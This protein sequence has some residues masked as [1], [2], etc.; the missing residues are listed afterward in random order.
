[1]YRLTIE[2]S[3]SSAHQLRGYKGKCENLHGHNWKVV[4]TVQG[5]TLNNIGILV[6]F[7]D[8]KRM[9]RD[10]LDE[11]DHI[12]MNEHEAFITQNP[13]SE[14]ISRYIYQDIERRLSDEK[15]T[16]V[17]VDSCTVYESETSRCTYSE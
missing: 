10:C 16:G 17:T 11:L 3:F 7:H 4:V 6:D 1:M 15:I 5:E 8:L 9:L 12:N 2:G 14:N 13:S